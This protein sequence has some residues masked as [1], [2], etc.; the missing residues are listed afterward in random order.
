LQTAAENKDVNFF[1]LSDTWKSL[2]SGG[3]SYLF[4]ALLSLKC[5]NWKKKYQDNLHKLQ[6]HFARWSTGQFSGDS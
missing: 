2:V 3:A 6:I 1:M 5:K 4:Q